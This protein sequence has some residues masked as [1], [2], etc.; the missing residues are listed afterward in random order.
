M[1]FIAIALLSLF[2][3][4]AFAQDAMSDSKDGIQWMSWSEAYTANKKEPK[5]IF[6]DIYTDWCG[7]C[8]K[9][10]KTTFKDE[11]VVKALGDDFYAVKLDAEMKDEIEFNGATFSWTPQGRNGTHQLAFALLDGKMGYP[12]F[13]MLDETFNRIMLSPGYKK[14]EQLMTELSYSSTNA[15]KEVNFDAFKKK[16]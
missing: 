1:K 14:P 16:K 5:K 15:Y 9:M 4:S 13:V 12:A 3:L 8:K 6:I 10:D 2:S 11:D 7:W